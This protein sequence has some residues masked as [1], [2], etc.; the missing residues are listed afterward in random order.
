MARKHVTP[1]KQVFDNFDLS[2]AGTSIETDC[3]Q[4]DRIRYDLNWTGAPIGNISVQVSNT[5]AVGSWKTLGI[6][7]SLDIVGI[8][9]SAEIDIENICWKYVRLSWSF[10]GG[11]GNLN[12]FY[13]AHSLGA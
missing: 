3:E 4:L 2:A 7:P 12:A 11:T 9:G 8:A 6:D 13:K 10:S 5:K 1:E